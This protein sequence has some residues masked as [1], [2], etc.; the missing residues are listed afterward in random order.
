MGYEAGIPGDRVG[1]LENLR[2]LTGYGFFYVSIFS[3][4][5]QGDI[6]SSVYI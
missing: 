6:I 4:L 3:W 2:I 1:G 5:T